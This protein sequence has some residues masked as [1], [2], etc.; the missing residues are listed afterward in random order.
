MQRAVGYHVKGRQTHS[1]K[2]LTPSQAT[3]LTRRRCDETF[4]L[5]FCEELKWL[6]GEVEEALKWEPGWI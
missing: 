3:R 2:G 1:Y 6:M 5:L 4:E